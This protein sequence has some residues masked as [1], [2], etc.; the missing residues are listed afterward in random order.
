MNYYLAISS[1][2]ATAAMAAMDETGRRNLHHT[3]H[4][5]D[6][7]E[8][9]QL[10]AFSVS[11]TSTGS[12]NKVCDPDEDFEIRL[13]IKRTLNNI[14]AS[15]LGLGVEHD[16]VDHA[17]FN[18]VDVELESEKVTDQDEMEVEEEAPKDEMA[19][20]EGVGVRGRRR[21]A[22]RWVYE[23]VASCYNCI[24]NIE[25]E[26][27]NWRGKEVGHMIVVPAS[28]IDALHETIASFF[29]SNEYHCMASK[30]FAIEMSFED[31]N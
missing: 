4:P 2:L 20:E 28:V 29:E 12:P 3:H 5:V 30:S 22:G 23:A 24:P 31:L 18:V 7:T 16:G 21:L 27:K 8:N 19:A 15:G 25:H 6:V 1:L 10:L 26:Q 9:I 14:G 17:T 11:L 13:L